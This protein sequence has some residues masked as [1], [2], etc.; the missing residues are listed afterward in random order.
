MD[1][2]YITGLRIDTVIGVYDWERTILQTLVIDVQM[3]TDTR[4]SA[5]KDDLN[6]TLDYGA[7]AARVTTLVSASRFAL[8]E[9][10]AETIAT[11]L[12][13]EFPI[14]SLTLKVGK[15]GAVANAE[16]VGVIINRC[17]EGACGSA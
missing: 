3:V 17:R 11:T 13:T 4:P 14:A 6:Q 9:A 10:L 8:L 12:L 5:R 15:P 16:D 1:I 7:V 2:V